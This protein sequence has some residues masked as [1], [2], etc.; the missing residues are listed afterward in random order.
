MDNEPQKIFEETVRVNTYECDFNQK[1]KPATVF[2]R[3]TETSN[4]HVMQ[5]GSGFE[6]LHARNLSWVLSRIKIKFYK[7]PGLEDTLTIRT[8]PKTIQQKLFYVRD[9]EIL[10]AQGNKQIAATSA[11]LIINTQT[12]H[13]IPPRMLNLNL[14]PVPDLFGLDEPLEKLTPIE[15]GFECSRIRAGYSAVDIVGHVNNSRYVEW[16]CNAFPMEMYDKGKIDWMQ[17]NYNQ[18]ILPSDEVAIVSSHIAPENGL[19]GVE[20]HN[21]SSD[22]RAFESLVHWQ[23]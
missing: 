18:E 9:F 4:L 1:W 7:F 13:L 21:L 15:K 19:W 17:I 16:I 12:R 22:S 5:W 20:G 6:D 23:D 11:W 14:P 8:W 2:Q 10:D 3:L